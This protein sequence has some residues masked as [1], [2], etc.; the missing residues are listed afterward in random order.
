MFKTNI[1]ILIVI[2]NEITFNKDYLKYFSELGNYWENRK[3]LILIG[4]CIKCNWVGI[5]TN[6]KELY[7]A[8]ENIFDFNV[9][10]ILTSELI[11]NNYFLGFKKSILD[12]FDIISDIDRI[13][14][15]P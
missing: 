1:K 3:K 2:K 14:I 7:L 6:I 12:I 13:L 15:E 9:K 4:Y 8:N 5:V 11:K 10:S